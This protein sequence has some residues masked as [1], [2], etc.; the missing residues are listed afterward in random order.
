MGLPVQ[1]ENTDLSAICQSAVDELAIAHPGAQIEFTEICQVIGQFDPSRMAQM[2]S[3]LI[4]NAVRHGD[5][6]HPVNVAL[7]VDGENAI[8]FVQNHG[9]PIPASALPSLFDPEGRYSRYVQ[10]KP[11]VS[12]GLGLGLF[13]AAQIVEGH[14]GKIDV[15]STKEE[16]TIFRVTLPVHL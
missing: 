4:G 6:Q 7:S 16:G 13:I 11:G 3:N 2:F 12:S 15:E 9:E 5:S 10:S 1:P 14:S 8:F